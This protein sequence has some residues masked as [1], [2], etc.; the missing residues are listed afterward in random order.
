MRIKIA[1]DA[2][3]IVC[4]SRLDIDQDFSKKTSVDKCIHIP[5]GY[6]EHDF[7]HVISESVKKNKFILLHLGAIGIERNPV[8][9]FKAIHALHEDGTITADSFTLRLIGN[10]EEE[11]LRTIKKENVGNFIEIMK[12]L[13]HQEALKQTE[14][15]DAM[16]LLVT[17]SKKNIRIL[18]GKTFEYLRTGKPILALGPPGGEVDRI[19]SEVNGGRLIAYEGHEQIRSFLGSLFKAWRADTIQHES[20]ELI[21]KYERKNLTAD[22]VKL[23]EE[24]I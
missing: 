1:L 7:K 24:L 16:L 23:F 3:K 15:A 11:I 18:P 10:V 21:K 8:Y 2:D 4:I 9:L 6:D 20:S 13:P 17:Q 5:N 22:L 12:Y 14:Q 19:L